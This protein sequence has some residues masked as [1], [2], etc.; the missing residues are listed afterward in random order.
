MAGRSLSEAWEARASEWLRWA[1][2][3]GHDVFFAEL[4]WPAFARLLP[5]PGRATLDVGCGEGRVGRALAA[6]GHRV[7]GVDSSSSLAALA[8][9]A[10]GYERVECATATQ[11]PFDDGAFDLAVAFMAL[12]D[13]DDP[14]AAVAEIARTLQPGGVLCVATVHPLN[15][16][17]TTPDD[18][19]GEH[20]FAQDMD[21]DG[22]AMTFES[23]DRPLEAYTGPLA[24]A[25]FVI[26]QLRE[27]RAAPGV[28]GPLA[29]AAVRPYF[30]HL[31]CRL[32]RP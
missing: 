17:A 29:V 28:E 20:R 18:Y 31:R 27:P 9:D 10:G 7:T 6:I 8:V 14:R 2:T 5:D 30:L 12:H 32:E 16:S 3:P 23:I 26:E 19:F 22:V 1:R 4:N 24:D 25:G 21:R 13:M 11:L 15:R